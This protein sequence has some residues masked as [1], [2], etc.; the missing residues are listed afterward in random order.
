M[1][2]RLCIGIALEHNNY[3]VAT[4]DHGRDLESMTFPADAAG[5]AALTSFVKSWHKPIRLAV[6]SAGTAA[7][8]MALALS[9]LP[10]SEVFLV[11]SAAA[12][13][14]AALARYAERAAI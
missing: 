10:Q 14:P 2:G 4:R 8:G 6:L 7:I 1:H 12:D 11:S 13:Q 5:T 3:L 9:D